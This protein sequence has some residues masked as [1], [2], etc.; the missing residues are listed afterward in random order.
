MSTDIVKISLSPEEI[1]NLPLINKGTAFTQEERDAL[2]LNGFLPTHIATIDEQIRRTYQNFHKKNTPLEKYVFLMGIMNRNELLFYQ[3]IMKYPEEMLPIIYTPTVGDAAVNYSQ[4]YF[5]QRGLYLSFPLMHKIDEIF[6]NYPRK[7]IQVIVVTDG[8]R[9]LGLG[10]Q[11]IGGMTI[12][13]GKLSLYTLF[14]GMHPAKTLPIFLDVGTNNPSLLNNDI[15]LGWRHARL[16]GETFDQF[17]E[18][19]VKSVKKW[20]PKVLLQ[21]EDFGRDNARRL[22]EKYRNQILSFND[23]I[24]GTASVTVGALF[25]AVK[26]LKEK[27]KDQRFAILGG[28]SAGTGI[29]DALVMAMKNDGL[30]HDEA[31]GRIY[32]V[33][34]EGLITERTKQIF[35]AQKPYVKSQ[36][37]MKGW[38]LHNPEHISMMD[39]VR[40]VRPTALIGV[41]GQT[42]AF[43]K[44]MIQEMSRFVKRPIIFPLSN[45]TSKA[46][47]VPQELIEWTEG[48]AIIATGSPFNPVTYKGKTYKIGQCN[49][50]YVFPGVGAGA[51]AVEAK[52]VSDTMFLEASKILSSFSPALKD[53]S[54][55][56]FPDIS[57]VRK[58]CRAIAIGTAIKA[59]EEGLSN[60][61]IADVEKKVDSIMWEPQ[62]PI[63]TRSALK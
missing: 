4:I 45:P 52:A 39:V 1:L 30:S 5:R 9:I 48:K 28:G 54:S 21:W 58:V 41:S 16:S 18:Q 50:V 60:V 8:E 47:A 33:D 2:G 15:Y 35:D 11:G 56:L 59:I 43:T 42:A 7:D 14:G 23:D 36:S 29:A 51:V 34:Q 49:N 12:P 62:Y 10:D 19:F 37:A 3:F 17:I 22:L 40:N 53:P 25:A 61:I 26:A 46:E 13:I 38:S 44:E 63:Y 6:S 57:E 27:L 55:S 20:F 32:L 24:Q 31:V